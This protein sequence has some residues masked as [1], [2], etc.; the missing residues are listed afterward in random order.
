MFGTK[1]L[2][3]ISVLEYDVTEGDMERRETGVHSVVI[4]NGSDRPVSSYQVNVTKARTWVGLISAVIGLAIMIGGM[5]WAG[6]KFGVK[7]EIHSQI[8]VECDPDGMIHEEIEQTSMEFIEEVQGV[9]QDDL[10]F[11][12]RRLNT[13]EDTGIRL[14]TGQHAIA[15]QQTRN[16]AE[17]KMLIQRAIDDGGP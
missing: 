13:V 2:R 1:N 6:V 5:V 3:S 4:Q 9:I 12:D 8:E 16:Q 11:M 7:S 17:L 14:E 10:D 15:D